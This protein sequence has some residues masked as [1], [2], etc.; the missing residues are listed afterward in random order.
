[1]ISQA[2]FRGPNGGNDEMIQIRNVSSVAQDIGGWKIVGTN[3][4]GTNTTRA[5]VPA[6]TS[7]PVGKAFLFVNGASGG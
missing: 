4:A 7:L 1:M 3:A 2:A 5:T 6:G